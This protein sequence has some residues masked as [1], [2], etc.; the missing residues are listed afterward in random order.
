MS[1]E[2]AAASV[3]G[4]CR[5]ARQAALRLAFGVTAC[6]ALVELLDG[7]ATVLAPRLAANMLVRQRC[8]SSLVQGLSVVVLITLSTGAVLVLTTAAMGTP[9]VLILAI[10]LLVY[11]SF[12]AHRRG[13]PDL[14][15]LLPQIS[16]VS[17]P[18]IAVLSPA[19]AGA[20]AE[21]LVMAD[22]KSVVEGK[23][24]SVRVDLGGRRIIKKKINQQ[25]NASHRQTNN[26][27]Q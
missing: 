12:Y 8:P 13:A 24:V 18:V 25:T 26:T 11:L 27:T 22:R 19:G 1:S 7:D 23:S 5:G 3:G 21:T 15:T 17:I 4:S 16:A 6:F 10:S 20:F 9:A 2:A 14:V